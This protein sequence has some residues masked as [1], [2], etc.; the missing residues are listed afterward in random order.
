MG[1]LSPSLAI[2]WKIVA[3]FG[4]TG[5][6]VKFNRQAMRAILIRFF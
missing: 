6:L 3:D 1:E 5:R 2:Q 4:M